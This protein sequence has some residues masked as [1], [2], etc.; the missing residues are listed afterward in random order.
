MRC[1]KHC[2][3]PPRNASHTPPLWSADSQMHRRFLISHRPIRAVL[4]QRAL[5]LNVTPSD[6]HS[7]DT[8]LLPAKLFHHL[9]SFDLLGWSLKLSTLSSPHPVRNGVQLVR[10]RVEASAPSITARR[11]LQQMVLI[12]DESVPELFANKHTDKTG[13]VIAN[14][15]RV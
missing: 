15:T 9:C 6:S 5:C 13:S 10:S 8:T 7:G 3:L 2:F 1:L 12:N 11:L 4:L 14:G